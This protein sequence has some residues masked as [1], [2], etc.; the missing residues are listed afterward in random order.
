MNIQGLV[1][2]IKKQK[3]IDSIWKFNLKKQDS[4]NMHSINKR[5]CSLFSCS[6]RFDYSGDSDDNGGSSG[7][8]GRGVVRDLWSRTINLGLSLPSVIK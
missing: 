8:N 5:F 2:S 7:D 1:L 6:D 3:N 4:M